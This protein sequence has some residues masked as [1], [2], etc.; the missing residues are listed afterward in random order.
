MLVCGL[1]KAAENPLGKLRFYETPLG[2]RCERC[3]EESVGL[4]IVSY[5]DPEDLVV[6]DCPACRGDDPLRCNTCAGF[7]VVRV[8]LNSIPVYRP[9]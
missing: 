1:C 8:S 7:G 4:P 2:T 9:E 6:I 5:R 3:R